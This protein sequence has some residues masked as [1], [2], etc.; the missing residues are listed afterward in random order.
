MR[1]ALGFYAL[2]ICAGFFLLCSYLRWQ[3]WLFRY[4]ITYFVLAMPLVAIAFVSCVRSAF[5]AA[6]A[7]LCMVNSILILGFNT[8]YPVYAPFLKLTREQHQFG[9]NQNLRRPYIALAEDI[10]RRGCTNVLLDCET[11]NFDYG[12]WVCLKDRGYLGTITEFMVT[13]QTAPLIEPD[14]TSK[15]AMVF[16]GNIPPNRLAEDIDGRMQPLLEVVYLGYFGNVAAQ[17]PSTFPG[18][19]CRLLGPENSAE[20][21]FT[22]SQTDAITPDKP[23]KFEFSCKPVSSDGLPLTNNV[24]RLA[25]DNHVGDVDLRTRTID[26]TA[27][28]TQP[29]AVIRTVLLDPLPTNSYP[30]Y[31]SDMKLSWDWAKKP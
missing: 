30:A 3:P 17:Y 12:L 2:A 4:H 7:A 18:K 1:N 20:L 10:L 9:S 24:L 26:L 29:S 28:A 11:Y 21:S 23:A 8:G 14:V 22:L 19:W 27:I 13:N 31:L 16:I 25:V 15:T 5:I 6:L